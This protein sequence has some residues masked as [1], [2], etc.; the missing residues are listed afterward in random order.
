M[1]LVIVSGLSGSGK[2][3]ALHT[4]EDAGYY[5]VDNLPLALLPAFVDTALLQPRRQGS[6]Q[7]TLPLERAAIGID[8]RGGI[9][10][11]PHLHQQL[12][13]L[14]EGRPELKVQLLFL[15]AEHEV[16]LRRFSESRR[17]HPLGREGLP[18]DQALLVE[19][20]LLAPLREAADL[21]LDTSRSTIHQLR[22]ML[23]ARLLKDDSLG[24]SLLLQSFG[25]KHGAPTD[26]DFIFDM[27]CLPNPHWDPHLRPLTGRDP[28]VAAF[29]SDLPEVRA[30]LDQLEQALLAWLPLF[31]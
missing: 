18:L 24:L 15:Y 30:M 16:L 20:E 4:L 12:A 11:L 9:S 3:I 22:A 27:R 5:C 26:S 6:E 10:E 17:P 13:R 29:L 14:R 25:F 31:E 28:E 23:R 21:I 19:A 2:T 8:V 1:K 7:A